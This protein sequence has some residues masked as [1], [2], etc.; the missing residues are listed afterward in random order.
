MKKSTSLL[1]PA[2]LG[3]K[4]HIVYIEVL[5]TAGTQGYKPYF[6]DIAREWIQQG[7][8]PHW[9]KQWT[10]LDDDLDIVAYVQEKYG[11]N[12]DMFKTV[13]TQLNVDPNN[14]FLNCTMDQ[15]INE[16]RIK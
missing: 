3:D 16:P 11:A 9:N 10:F 5:S 2:S 7:G 15:V 1:C 4:D 6:T 8:V 13:R 14:R 12:L